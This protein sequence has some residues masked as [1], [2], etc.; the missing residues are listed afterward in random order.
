MFPL[1]LGAI[2]LNLCVM[3]VTLNNKMNELIQ[4]GRESLTLQT[5]QLA[6]ITRMYKGNSYE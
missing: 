2:L 3:S 4:I 5:E 6:I 1:V